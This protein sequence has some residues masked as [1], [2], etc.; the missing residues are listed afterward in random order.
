MKKVFS[1]EKYFKVEGREAWDTLGRLGIPEDK[2]WPNICDGKTPKECNKLGYEI[3]DDWC[4][5]VDDDQKEEKKMNVKKFRCVGYKKKERSFTVGKVYEEIDGNMIS[6]E[7]FKYREIFGKAP[8]EWLSWWYVFEEVTENAPKM[9]IQDFINKKISVTFDSLKQE[10]KFLKLCAA[11][12]LKWSFGC[13]A[14]KYDA[15]YYGFAEDGESIV[16]GKKVKA[17]S[18]CRRSYHEIIGYKSVPASAFFAADEKPAEKYKVT[19]ECVDGKTT[20][21][22]LIVNG[23]EVKYAKSRCNPEDKFSIATG[24]KLAL[25][26]LFQKK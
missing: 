22:K 14:D 18:H 1:K 9:T 17:L 16:F 4:I 6:D 3:N 7:G 23:I 24:A 8:H 21:A 15:D 10:K 13:C 19:I 12:G 11:N 25:D 20:T 2:R 5:E 26:R